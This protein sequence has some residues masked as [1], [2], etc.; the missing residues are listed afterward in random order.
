MRSLTTHFTRHLPRRALLPSLAGEAP[1]RLDRF[2]P[3]FRFTSFFAP[4]DTLLC[5]LAAEGALAGLRGRRPRSAELGPPASGQLLG[6]TSS[7]PSNGAAPP[8]RIVE[9][10]TGSGLVGLRLLDVEPRSTLFGVDIDHEAPAVARANAERLGLG[11][12][13]RFERASIWERAVER[14]L[15]AEPVDLLVCNPPYIPEPPGAALPVEAGAGPDGAAHV[16]RVIEIANLARPT[17]LALSWCS[18]C[19]PAGVV[20]DAERA[21]YRLDAL[22][23]VA[24][25]D[26]E[27]SGGVHRY[28]RGLPTAFFSDLP[29]VVAEVAPDGAARF[30]Y[31]LLAGVF[32]D[33]RAS[34]QKGGDRRTNGD[35]A[36]AVDALVRDFVARG[37]DALVAPAA[38]FPVSAWILDRWDEI[39]LRA[40]LHGALV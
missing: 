9:L 4:E 15:L 6:G 8:L 5:V 33:E 11:G 25:G 23:A 22:Y 32:H 27:Y 18:L 17:A 10:T 34:V 31:L 39:A 40:F 7:S 24:I 3:P 12:R 26:G 2:V 30:A 1:S 38:P 14:G 19:D 29:D 28:L 36:V 13:A 37:V 35:S 20:A 21:G 16:R